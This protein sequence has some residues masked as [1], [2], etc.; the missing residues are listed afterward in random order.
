M[1]TATDSEKNATIAPHPVTSMRW[2]NEQ[3]PLGAPQVRTSKDKETE[4][5]F[6]KAKGMGLCLSC[7]EGIGWE[8]M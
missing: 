6:K 1:G 3:P 5:D 4:E 2:R 7:P 8:G